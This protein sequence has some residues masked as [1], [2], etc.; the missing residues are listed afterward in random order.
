M[1]ELEVGI[2]GK[3]LLKRSSESHN[4]LLAQGCGSL[5]SLL[6]IR[7][8]FFSWRLAIPRSMWWWVLSTNSPRDTFLSS[9]TQV[10]LWG[11]SWWRT[12]NGSPRKQSWRRVISS[13]PS[14]SFYFSGMQS[15]QPPSLPQKGCYVLDWRCSQN[16]QQNSP[17]L[18]Q[19]QRQWLPQDYSWFSVL[20]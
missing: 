4:Q 10:L 16:V 14:W 6:N 2:S 9:A 20:A 3:T 13:G 12:S 8:L 15:V 11:P 5:S 1:V 18:I 19:P 7:Y 17:L